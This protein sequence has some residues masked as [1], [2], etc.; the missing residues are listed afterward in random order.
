MDDRERQNYEDVI[1]ETDLRAQAERNKY[2]QQEVMMGQADASMIGEQLSLD[3]EKKEAYYQLKGFTMEV[4]PDTE[5]VKWVRRENEDLSFLTEA[6]VNYC[7][8]ILCGY[9]NKNI[10]LGNYTDEEILPKVEDIG[11]TINDALFMKSNKY[12]KDVTIEECKRELKDRITKK[13]NLR[14]FAYEIVGKKADE[15]EIKRQILNEIEPTIEEELGKIKAH[16]VNDRLKMLD[17]LVQWMLN[18]IHGA[19][20]R[21]LNGQE[22]KTLREHTHISEARGMPMPV[23]Q[24]GGILDYFKKK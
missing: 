8:W 15:E 24:R 16:L 6:G 17:S 13:I 20:K 12:F 2:I 18:Q 3:K 7:F 21:A 14:K 23:Q 9:L 1:R 11:N 22:R 4:D 10:L 5:E 19:Y